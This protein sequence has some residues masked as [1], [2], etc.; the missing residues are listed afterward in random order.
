VAH[1]APGRVVQFDLLQ[2]ELRTRKPVK[3]PDVVDPDHVL[4][5]EIEH[6]ASTASRSGSDRLI[7]TAADRSPFR[8][9]AG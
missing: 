5:L 4:D 2:M 9:S 7:M 8:S 6:A 3:I 1:V